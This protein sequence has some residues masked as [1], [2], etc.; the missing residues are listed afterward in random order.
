MPEKKW[1]NPKAEKTF[2]AVQTI[3]REIRSARA[4][5]SI[6]PSAKIAM[7]LKAPKQL[8]EQSLL[9]A[10]L[11]KTSIVIP[12]ANSVIPSSKGGSASGGSPEGSRRL[13]TL[14]PDI[15]GAKIHLDLRAY[16]N[17]EKETARLKKTITETETYI[18]RLTL[19]LKDKNFLKNAPRDIVS[20]KKA[21]A[22]KQETRL[23]KLRE[24]L[25]SI[26]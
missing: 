22:A 9:I 20:T 18:S 5:F 7:H 15:P 13:L 8:A 19:Q 4:D 23:K 16:I 21:D 12:S 6:P 11:A 2:A 17:P 1:L 24:Q 26:K 25:Q 14:H 10:H 3:I